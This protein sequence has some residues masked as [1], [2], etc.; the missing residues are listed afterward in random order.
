M[1]YPIGIQDFK[2]LREGGFVY[3]DKTALVYDMVTRGK[4]Y[5]LSRP[6]RFGKSILVSTL[7][8]YFKGERELFKGLAIDGMEK[9]WEK[10]T[11]FHIDFNGLNFEKPDV[12]GST[13]NDYLVKLENEYLVENSSDL[14]FGRRFCNILEQVHRQTG[15]CCVVLVDE[16]DKPLL[17]V[18]DSGLRM[19]DGKC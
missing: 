2:F 5:F 15:K 19:K 13:L 3:V 14:D 9:N 7:E 11:V 1:K 4:T 6:R 17:D 8:Y 18:M 12:L 16:Y 10:H